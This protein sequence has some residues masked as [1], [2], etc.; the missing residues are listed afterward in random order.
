MA[1]VAEAISYQVTDVSGYE[2]Y[3]ELRYGQNGS[4]F[5][6][7][8]TQAGSS[9]SDTL[10]GRVTWDSN[11]SDGFD[12]GWQSIELI[13][14]V[15]SEGSTLQWSVGGTTL[16]YY[17]GAFNT[18]EQIQIQSAVTTQAALS[19]DSLQVSFYSSG[20]QTESCSTTTGPTVDQMSQSGS[21]TMEKFVT[22]TPQSGSN[23]D[24]VHIT[25]NV[26]LMA[27]QGV[28]LTANSIFGKVFIDA[29]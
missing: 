29:A 14:H 16:E 8:E 9:P 6:G 25:A 4:G 17:A 27:P 13:V 21:G 23:V 7:Y 24:E 19:W 1:I 2:L 11:T 5:C 20:V 26:R 18:I 22:I 3:S 28:P 10:L 12:S 15:G